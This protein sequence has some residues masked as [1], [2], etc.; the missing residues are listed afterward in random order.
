[1]HETAIVN[2]P[3]V[4]G[5]LSLASCA[6]ALTNQSA[7]AEASD[8]GESAHSP[9]D[10]VFPEPRSMGLHVAA[11]VL[12]LNASKS[13]EASM[14]EAVWRRLPSIRE[15]SEEGFFLFQDDTMMKCFPENS[16]DGRFCHGN[17]GGLFA[18]LEE[19]AAAGASVGSGR[20]VRSG[21]A[22]EVGTS[23]S[24]SAV[25]RQCSAACESAHDS[26]E[27]CL[28]LDLQEPEVSVECGHEGTHMEVRTTVC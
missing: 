2:P 24:A 23:E 26:H 21:Q 4:G 13:R 5:L 20:A 6:D 1:M 15:L 9:S 10:A 28:S 25:L 17:A 27:E 18:S 12:P 8:L 16:L 19:G 22:A 7:L 11:E 3:K 14:C